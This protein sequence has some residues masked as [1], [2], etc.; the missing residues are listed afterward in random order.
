MVS[1][2][3]F[4]LE[5]YVSLETQE[6]I[7]DLEDIIKRINS[8]RLSQAHIRQ[9]LASAHDVVRPL[10]QV[11]DEKQISEK[12]VENTA[13]TEMLKLQEA[14]EQACGAKRNQ[15]QDKIRLAQ[16]NSIEDLAFDND[17]IIAL[18]IESVKRG[19][20]YFKPGSNNMTIELYNDEL[21]KTVFKVSISMA[22]LIT[23]M[24]NFNFG[25]EE[26]DVPFKMG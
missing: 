23:F 19:R 16:Q 4:K 20:I 21:G 7:K 12:R 17:L 24:E 2:Q 15:L 8:S 18:I 14:I 26:L 13:L 10:D 11:E 9:D 25:L 6:N 22:N 5:E 1:L 3:D